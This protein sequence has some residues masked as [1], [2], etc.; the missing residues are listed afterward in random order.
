MSFILGEDGTLIREVSSDSIVYDID[1]D[2]SNTYATDHE[3]EN[4]HLT[5]LLLIGGVVGGIAGKILL[6]FGHESASI[7]VG[8]V[9]G[10]VVNWILYQRIDKR[11]PMT[12]CYCLGFVLPVVGII[13]AVIVVVCVLLAIIAMVLAGGG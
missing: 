9:I 8:G 11:G 2:N 10:L 1:Y 4:M 5:A 7:L 3:D 12:L 13:G 6:E